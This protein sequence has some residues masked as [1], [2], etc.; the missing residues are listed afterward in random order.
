MH[1]HTQTH[2]QRRMQV[3]VTERQ[4]QNAT[5][6]KEEEN[7]QAEQVTWSVLAR[8]SLI[9]AIVHSSIRL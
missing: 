2:A 3:T 7:N 5:R 4:Q 6:A 9:I 8:S 1:K